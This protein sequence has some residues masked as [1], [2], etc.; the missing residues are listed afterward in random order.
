MLSAGSGLSL[1]IASKTLCSCSVARFV[2]KVRPNDVRSNL[3]CGV[4]VSLLVPQERHWPKPVRTSLCDEAA[5]RCRS[6]S[7]SFTACRFIQILYRIRVC[8]L[9]TDFKGYP[10]IEGDPEIWSKTAKTP[11]GAGECRRSARS[12]RAKCNESELAQRKP[13]GKT[14]SKEVRPGLCDEAS[15]AMQE[16]LFSR[17]CFAQY[18]FLLNLIENFRFSLFSTRRKVYSL[19]KVFLEEEEQ[20]NDGEEHKK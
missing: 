11:R 2:A 4:S 13:P 8:V 5:Q 17:S 20:Q 10:F 12:T 6:T 9:E 15:E 19:D 16:H 3:S 7:Q 14:W 1:L 18:R